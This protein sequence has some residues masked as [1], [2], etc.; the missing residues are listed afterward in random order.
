MSYTPAITI[1]EGPRF[2][3]ERSFRVSDFQNFITTVF[4][5]GYIYVN[6]FFLC[7]FRNKITEKS[8][9]HARFNLFILLEETRDF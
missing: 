7:S 9:S 4:L 2:D 5:F 3:L 1:F 8:F 6:T